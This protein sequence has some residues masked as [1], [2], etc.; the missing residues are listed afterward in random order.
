ML[1][2][3]FVWLELATRRDLRQ[4]LAAETDRLVH[5]GLLLHVGCRTASDIEVRSE[6]LAIVHLVQERLTIRALVN[7]AILNPLE[8]VHDHWFSLVVS[9]LTVVGLSV[10]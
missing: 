2:T 4:F 8:R 5:D 10:Y 1:V 9:E 7:H 6:L 3:H